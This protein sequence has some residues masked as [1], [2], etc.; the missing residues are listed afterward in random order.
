[1]GAEGGG[2]RRSAEDAPRQAPD[3]PV[4]HRA[5]EGLGAQRPEDHAEGDAEGPV[6]GTVFKVERG[7][8]GE[9]IAYVRVFSGTVRVRETYSG[10]L[11]EI[12]PG[13]VNVNDGRT[14]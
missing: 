7:T 9:K 13:A 8:A 5:D 4:G 6:S 3:E 2:P 14:S 1:M 10:S 11:R 12:V